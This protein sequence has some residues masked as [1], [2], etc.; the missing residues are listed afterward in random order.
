MD[1]I[2]TTFDL[3]TGMI[4]SDPEKTTDVTLWRF[5]KLTPRDTG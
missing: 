1:V 4:G 5:E 2:P 3:L